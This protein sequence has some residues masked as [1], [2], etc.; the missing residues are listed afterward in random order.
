MKTK[1]INFLNCVL[2]RRKKFLIFFS[3]DAATHYIKAWKLS[4]QNDPVLGYR[5]GIYFMK[6]KKYADAIAT[7]Q[8]VFKNTSDHGKLRK[9]IYEKA[10][11]LLRT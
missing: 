3:G 7:C 4:S 5:L 9:E 2:D 1:I 6:V 10:I 11:A 8:T